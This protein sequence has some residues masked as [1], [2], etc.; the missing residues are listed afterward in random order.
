LLLFFPCAMTIALYSHNKQQFYSMM[1]FIAL[2]SLII[3]SAGCIINDLID[4]SIDRMVAR[5]KNRPLASGAVS[6]NEALILLCFLLSLL[7]FA[8]V[9]LPAAAQICSLLA[10]P[11]ILIYPTLKRFTYLPQV[12]LGL[13]F[14]FGIFITYYIINNSATYSLII[15][16]L[17]CVFWTLAYDTIYGFM[18]YKDDQKIGVKSFALLLINKNYKLWL[19]LFYIIFIA[20]VTCSLYLVHNKVNIAACIILLCAFAALAWQ[21]H[22]LDKDLPNKCLVCFKSN[23]IVGALVLLA[24]SLMFLY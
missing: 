7:L 5:T 13:I 24:Y 23:N 16:Y 10:L 15:L 3:R 20:S 4:K 18:D 14:N 21:I 17:G 11:M 9:K 2:C 8:L 12:F 6:V 1:A 19:A 22:Y